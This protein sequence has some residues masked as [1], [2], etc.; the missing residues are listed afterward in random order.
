[1]STVPQHPGLEPTDTDN[2]NA[3]T[4]MMT[5]GSWRSMVQRAG[6]AYLITRVCVM[7]GAGVVAAQQIA[8]KREDP[9]FVRPSS[10]VGEL[11]KVLTSW[12]GAWYLRIVRNGYP[13][14]IPPDVTFDMTQARAAFFP[15]F[16]TLV[17]WVDYVLPGGDTFA[18]IFLNTVFGA[19][20]VYVVGLLA[21]QLFGDRAGYR[22]MLIMAFFPG[23][24][25]LTFMYSEATL[26][27]VSA[28]CLLM[29]VRERWWLA[30]VLA[31]VGTATRPNGVALCAACAV[32]AFLAI[33]ERR[34]WMSLAAPVL[35]PIGL[36][37]FQTYLRIR[38]GE[39]AWIRVQ[40]EAWDE[41]TSFGL[42][43]LRNTWEAFIH[44]LSS[45]TDILT[46]VSFIVMLLVAV[47]MWRQRLPWPLVAYT[48]VVLALMI[49]P[50]T[51]TA[52]PRFLYTAFPAFISLA[53]WWPEEHE[54][55][56]GAAVA[57]SAAG[58]V[59]LTG[60]YG[61]LGAIP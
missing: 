45:P 24:F 58:L 50:S 15:V 12:D 42:T 46:A 47:I 32:A 41:G 37:A 61:V 44:P 53:A 2:S 1:M 7:A 35:S 30:G 55:A 23:S 3:I 34:N 26:I 4:T 28:A 18:G 52:R 40:R 33:R 25:V 17:R 56:W 11:V 20:A 14:S 29:L 8:E 5:G 27:L 36:I 39:W 19:L 59:T 51:V 6:I 57:L 43:A 48:A 10:A 22:A 16:P 49:L 9:T 13:K 31:A 60:L 21:R 38:T 54:E